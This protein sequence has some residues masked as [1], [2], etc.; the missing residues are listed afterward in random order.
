MEDARRLHNPAAV[1]PEQPPAFNDQNRD[2]HPPLNHDKRLFYFVIIV[3]SFVL[4]TM[5]LLILILHQFAV[6]P[7][8]PQFSVS[9]AS[10]SSFNLSSSNLTAVWD[11]V[12]S[13]R[14]PN[15]KTSLRYLNADASIVYRSSILSGAALLPFSQGENNETSLTSRLAAI[16][17]YVADASYLAADC[18]HGLVE[19][20]VRL[21]SWLRFRH[22]GFYPNDRLIR[23]R[24]SHVQVSFSSPQ[25]PASPFGGPRNCTVDE[26]LEE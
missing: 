20:E 2:H 21:F 23:V 25:G 22:A 4:F 5:I 7:R 19:V 6:K 26:P 14:N 12:F 16:Q 18:S 11:V 8:L 17:S 24:C 13:I 3:S 1:Y 15:K 10:V 9:S